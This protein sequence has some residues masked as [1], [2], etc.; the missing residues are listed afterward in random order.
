MPRRA[1]EARAELFP[2]GPLPFL[3]LAVPFV[4]CV[5]P[6]LRVAIA[7]VELRTGLPIG[8]GGVP[9]GEKRRG[10]QLVFHLQVGELFRRVVRRQTL[11]KRVTRRVTPQEFTA[12]VPET[13]R[14]VPPV[15]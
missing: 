4:D 2:P 9:Q 6:F 3:R 13:I 8:L 14:L 1:V 12:R 11:R 15:D 7:S 10:F 5:E